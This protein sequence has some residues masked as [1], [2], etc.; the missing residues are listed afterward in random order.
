MK[1]E[2]SGHPTH[3]VLCLEEQIAENLPPLQRRTIPLPC[4]KHGDPYDILSPEWTFYFNL[5]QVVYPYSQF[6]SVRKGGKGETEEKSILNLEVLSL[7]C[8][9]MNL[10]FKCAWEKVQ[11]IYEVWNE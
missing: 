1:W 5:F 4:P 2:K 6:I 11:T 8:H 9:E 3:C 10:R 7:V